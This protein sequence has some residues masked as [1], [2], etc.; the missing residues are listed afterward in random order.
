MTTKLTA[1]LRDSLIVTI[2]SLLFSSPGF[3]LGAP[4]GNLFGGVNTWSLA[5]FQDQVVRGI[6]LDDNGDPLSGATV[7]LD[8]GRS[9]VTNEKGEFNFPFRGTVT[10]KISSVGF[11]EKTVVVNNPNTVVRVN[12]S[13]DSQELEQVTVTALGLSKK[14]RSVGYAIAEVNGSAVQQAKESNFVNALQGKLAGV[15]INT[16]SGSMGGSTKVIVR[17]NKSITGDNNALFVVDGVVMGNENAM[18]TYN[19]Q[20]GGGGFD[21]GSPIQDINPDDIEQISVLKGASATALYG[22]RGAN[23]VVLI[24]TK[25]GSRKSRLGISFNSSFEINRVSYLPKFQNR[26]GGGGAV[27][28][29][30]SFEASGFDTLWQSVNPE[31]FKNAPTYTD[32][33]KGGYDLYPQFGVDESWGRSY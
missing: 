23:G 3:S 15:Q 16:N 33:V 8:D 22:S 5:S 2:V 17:G 19:Q 30:P 27:P 14:T 4:A 12:L 7:V 26:Y 25:K 10:L 18:P 13:F 31:L 24:T 1:L 6:V 29:D 20:I 9:V 21:Y 32:P 11:R 28:N